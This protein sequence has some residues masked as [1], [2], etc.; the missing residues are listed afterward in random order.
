MSAPLGRVVRVR[1][2]GLV[3]WHQLLLVTTSGGTVAYLFELGK[4]GLRDFVGITVIWLI[5]T[6]VFGVLTLSVKSTYPTSIEL[7]AERI[8]LKSWLGTKKIRWEEIG[9]PTF[10]EKGY[11]WFGTGLNAADYGGSVLRVNGEVARLILASPRRRAWVPSPDLAQ[12]IA[13]LDS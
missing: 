5:L 4:W 13:T 3:Y 10:V 11:V 12:K 6:G 8:E 1:S 7:F 9:P 2:R